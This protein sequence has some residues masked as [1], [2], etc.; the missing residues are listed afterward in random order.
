[1]E[2]CFVYRLSDCKNVCGLFHWKFLHICE[3]LIQKPYIMFHLYWSAAPWNIESAEQKRET[4]DLSPLTFTAKHFPIRLL[5]FAKTGLW[6]KMCINC[7]QWQINSFEVSAHDCWIYHL[8]MIVNYR[9]TAEL[10][11]YH[12]YRWKVSK[13]ERILYI[14]LYA[15]TSYSSPL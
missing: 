7:H 5:S 8:K 9:A 1:M 14:N 2:M 3:C 15:K 11:F 6:M 4:F 13:K 12:N 10:I